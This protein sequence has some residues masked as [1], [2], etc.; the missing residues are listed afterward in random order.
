MKNYRCI[1]EYDGTNFSGFQV[2]PGKR[3]VQSRIEFGLNLFLKEDIKIFAS[4]RTDAGVHALGQVFNFST[5]TKIPFSNIKKSLNNFIDDDITIVDIEEVNIN[6]HSRFYSVSKTYLY[7]IYNS[8]VRSSIHRNYSFHVSERLDIDLMQR[9]ADKLIGKKDFKSFM[10]SR[11]GKVNT[12]REIYYIRINKT[13]D[14][15]EL[16]FKGNG[17]LYNMVRIIVGMLVDVSK[18]VID[19]EEI[20]D[21]IKSKDRTRL[22]HTAPAS[23]LY[24]KSVEYL[25]DSSKIPEDKMKNFLNRG[26]NKE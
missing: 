13:D 10:A 9:T 11:S 23:G 5:E 18:G 17:F 2:Q 16:E 20:D 6:F 24:L 19:I 25:E 7:K 26:N 1:V 12:V 15:I 8:K 22:R 21:I 14:F 3:T 4:G